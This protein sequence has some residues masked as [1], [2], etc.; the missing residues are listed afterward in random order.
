MIKMQIDDIRGVDIDNKT[1]SYNVLKKKSVQQDS[2]KVKMETQMGIQ[3][4]GQ[5][6][7]KMDA[8]MKEYSK[9]HEENK[10]PDECTFFRFSIFILKEHTFETLNVSC[11]ISLDLCFLNKCFIADIL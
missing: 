2:M 10:F 3:I 1:D 6:D 7:G 5:M 11:F 9:R 4:D 8:Q